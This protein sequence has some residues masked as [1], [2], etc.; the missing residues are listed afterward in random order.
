MVKLSRLD[1]LQAAALRSLK[2]TFYWHGLLCAT[3]PF[4]VVF[5]VAVIAGLLSFPALPVVVGPYSKAFHDRTQARLWRKD[6]AMPMS[7]SEPSWVKDPPMLRVLPI[8]T[9]FANGADV[10]RHDVMKKAGFWLPREIADFKTNIDGKEINIHDFCVLRHHEGKN[11]RNCAILSVGH[12]WENNMTKLENDPTLQELSKQFVPY[13]SKMLGV[14]Q[15]EED[16]MGISREYFIEGLR[17][18]DGFG[19]Q[20]L[21][22]RAITLLILL[23]PVVSAKQSKLE[24]HFLHALNA[25]LLHG[26]DISYDV[27]D[28]VYYPKS[29]PKVDD[30]I[31]F[32]VV[33]VLLFFYVY[34]N[35]Y[36]MPSVKSKFGLG[37]GA[38]AILVLTMSMAVGICN[39]LGFSATLVAEEIVPFLVVAIGMENML[40]ITRSVAAMSWD[41][42]VNFRVAEGLAH[43]G[44]QLAR[45]LILMESVLLMGVYSSFK[46][47]Q[48]FCVIACVSVLCDFFLEIMAFVSI[49]SLDLRRMELSDLS[50]GKKL[51]E[52]S[53]GERP[54][55]P[56]AATPTNDVTFPD[57]VQDNSQYKYAWVSTYAWLRQNRIALWNNLLALLV[58]V[59]TLIL[60]LLGSAGG[61]VYR[62]RQRLDSIDWRLLVSQENHLNEMV[63]GTVAIMSPIRIV[64]TPLS[65][66]ISNVPFVSLPEVPAW[67]Q[68]GLQSPLTITAMVASLV[69]GIIILHKLGQFL[70]LQVFGDRE[71]DDAVEA[72]GVVQNFDIATLSGHGQ[73]VE[74]LTVMKTRSTDKPLDHIVISTCLRGQIRV[75]NTKSQR[76][77]Q[78]FSPA[79]TS[80]P[81][82][83]AAFENIVAIGFGNGQV[84]IIDLAM[85]NSC[86]LPPV[87]PL[88]GEGLRNN[89][90]GGGVTSLEFMGDTLIAA[91]ATGVIQCWKWNKRE[92]F[93]GRESTTLG[94]KHTHDNRRDS[95]PTCGSHGNLVAFFASRDINQNMDENQNSSSSDA[96]GATATTG[97]IETP[98]T[99]SPELA[100]VSFDCIYKSKI[101]KANITAIKIHGN[102]IITAS[103]DRVVKILK[104]DLTVVSVLNGHEGAVT[105]ID[106]SKNRGILVTGSNDATLRLWNLKEGL[107]NNVLRG[108]EEAVVA[109]HANNMH[110]ASS[111]DDDTL[112]IWFL[113]SGEC[114]RIL[115]NFGAPEFILHPSSIMV[116]VNE[117]SL[118]VWDLR[119]GGNGER[120]RVIPLVDDTVPAVHGVEAK[121]SGTNN[122]LLSGNVV[123]CDHGRYIKAV[124]LPFPNAKF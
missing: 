1:S 97:Q 4:R 57:G 78:T 70:Q 67:M 8:T 82:C 101:H 13:T 79:L 95:C 116:T 123:L 24:T 85:E 59:A 14:F 51:S 89:D 115:D 3:N 23:E 17:G 68:T 50:T 99:V 29:K 91:T 124:E 76:C 62:T 34:L 39:I 40:V 108:H 121:S 22:A 60:S 46:S 9:Y 48:E 20:Y 41:I 56:L 26:E 75:W 28:Y 45:S 53:E 44:P 77:L 25:E 100:R 54:F 49:L 18:V 94:H 27:M 106:V 69:V 72:F 12:L 73:D 37:V 86:L 74:C 96:A 81:W 2:A 93:D 38:V 71:S 112:R 118:S 111:S 80:A 83:L 47:L 98:R 87:G 64:M 19:M 7:K 42:P 21:T 119:G 6:V 113:S 15:G 84:E 88:P 30:S 110:V 52:N 5:S 33:Y 104:P 16:P 120:L 90:D 55:A 35:V 114:L 32:V 92:D 107:C 61:N 102:Q 117:G 10:L 63:S 109:V 36:N 66:N 58:I 11:V 65:H 43:A 122:I 103:S 105:S 31:F